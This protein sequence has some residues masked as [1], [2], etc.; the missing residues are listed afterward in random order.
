MIVSG[1]AALG[2]GTLEGDE[3]SLA[4]Q[5]F[6]HVGGTTPLASQTRHSFQPNLTR[7]D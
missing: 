4:P 3:E 6:P 5:V 1:I 7:T 2:A